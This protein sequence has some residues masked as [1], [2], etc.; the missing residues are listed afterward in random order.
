MGT[1]AK[2]LRQDTSRAVEVARLTYSIVYD[3]PQIDFGF[4][5]KF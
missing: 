4:E 1:V 3:E 5:N 2:Y